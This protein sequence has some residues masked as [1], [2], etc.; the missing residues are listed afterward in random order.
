LSAKTP[1]ELGL[2]PRFEEAMK[3]RLGASGI[4]V[5]VD[6]KYYLDESR[7]R[8]VGEWT[9]GE[10]DAGSQYNTRRRML[11]LR[12]ARMI[13]G[14]IVVALVLYDLLYVG[15]ATLRYLIV[16]LLFVWLVLTLSQLYW[17]S[18]VRHRMVSGA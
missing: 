6:G 10:M 11:E 1:Q 15:G 18:R 4:F 17:L 16:V 9:K 14:V 3:R 7:L 5:E 12:I 8:Q 13:L 2:P